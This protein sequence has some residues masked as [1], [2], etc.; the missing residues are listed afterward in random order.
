MITETIEQHRQKIESQY[1]TKDL[2]LKVYIRITR[3]NAI[4]PK[5]K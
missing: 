5:K 2:E 4:S 3:R 1:N